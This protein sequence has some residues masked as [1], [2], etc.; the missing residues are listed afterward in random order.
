MKIEIGYKLSPLGRTYVGSRASMSRDSV[1]TC[2]TEVLTKLLQEHGLPVS[3]EIL[4]FE[5]NIGGW[6][7]RH[8]QSLNGYGCSASVET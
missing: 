4:D 7:S 1:R 2:G 3:L 5:A 6:C 8:T